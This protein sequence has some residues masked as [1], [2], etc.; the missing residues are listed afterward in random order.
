MDSVFCSKALQRGAFR[1]F[2]GLP[3]SSTITTHHLPA[4][5][6]CNWYHAFH[7]HTLNPSLLCWLAGLC[8]SS[9]TKL[10][11][12]RTH[13]YEFHVL[14]QPVQLP[15]THCNARA[16][17]GWLF[18]SFSSHLNKISP[19]FSSLLTFVAIFI[20]GLWDAGWL[21]TWAT[22]SLSQNYCAALSLT[23]YLSAGAWVGPG[24]VFV[25]HIFLPGN[26]WLQQG[27]EALEP[28]QI[29]PQ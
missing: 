13:V 2:K 5:Y 21:I 10:P 18:P 12:W 15:I 27:Q 25:L 11:V 7:R 6:M 17:L 1:A 24:F 9:Y 16:V 29:L 26:F 23:I 19:F 3:S 8:T 28:P 4:K 22:C 20:C 14:L